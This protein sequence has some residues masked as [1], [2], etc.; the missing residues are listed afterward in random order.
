MALPS[1]ESLKLEAEYDLVV[2]GSGGGSMAAA[3]Y[4]KK[5]GLNPVILEKLE[6]IGGSTGYSGGVW[7]VP[8]HHVLARHGVHD[9]MD[10]ARKYFEAVRTFKGKGTT[11]ERTDAF[12]QEAPK[13]IQFLEDEGMVYY[14]PDGWA[15][16]YDSAPGGNSHGRSLM[17]EPFNFN[18][19]AAA[20]GPAEAAE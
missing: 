7:W 10:E 12:L 14:Y 11:P 13:M 3:L 1:P 17:A 19:L 16:Y 18:A 5:N 20:I 8:N 9:S 6:K 15:D 2:V 4:A